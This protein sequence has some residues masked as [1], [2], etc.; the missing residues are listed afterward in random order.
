MFVCPYLSKKKKKRK[1]N[2]NDVVLVRL[3]FL[4]L[5]VYHIMRTR[6]PASLHISPNNKVQR[7]GLIRKG[8]IGRL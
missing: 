8:L 1:K 2:K 4:V 6:E 7:D 3:L 5:I